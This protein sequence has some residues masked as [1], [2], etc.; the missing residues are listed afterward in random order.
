MPFF[1]KFTGL[2]YLKMAFRKTNRRKTRRAKRAPVKRQIRRQSQAYKPKRK[3]QFKMM[4]QPFVETKKKLSGLTY[5]GSLP[6]ASHAENFKVAN[7]PYGY[8]GEQAAN[9]A[10][11]PVRRTWRNQNISPIFTFM[12][13]TQGTDKDEMIGQDVFSKYLTQKIQIELP[14]PGP[15]SNVAAT[16]PALQPLANRIVRPC[17]IYVYWGW[18]KRPV[19]Y[20]GGSPQDMITHITDIVKDSLEDGARLLGNANTRGDMLS[21]FLTFQTKRNEIFTVQ[22]K[23]LSHT[24]VKESV[25]RPNTDVY[26]FIHNQNEEGS[27]LPNNN[28]ANYGDYLTTGYANKLQTT[29]SWKTN[30]KIRYHILGNSGTQLNTPTALD[31]WIP[32]SYVCVPQEFQEAMSTATD[33]S[34]TYPASGAPGSTAFNAVDLVGDCVI[35]TNTA[36]YFSDS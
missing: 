35:K 11:E 15:L 36:H 9:P 8:V 4:R 24:K 7:P 6:S 21:D 27:N 23:L 22:R 34:Y 3:R 13:M 18:I 32:Y 25:R 29:I 1:I 10:V 5:H 26:Q 14:K 12:T 20:F 16:N 17:Q 31:S 33:N 2:S 30:R 19:S 28:Q